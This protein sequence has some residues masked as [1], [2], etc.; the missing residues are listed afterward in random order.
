MKTLAKS[1]IEVLD[2]KARAGSTEPSWLGFQNGNGTEIGK[3]IEALI[4]KAKRL[5]S[6]DK[7]SLKRVWLRNLKKANKIPGLSFCF[8]HRDKVYVCTN[9]RHGWTEPQELRMI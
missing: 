1:V 4:R 7:E 9:G 5:H 2:I 3:E 6:Q 8:I